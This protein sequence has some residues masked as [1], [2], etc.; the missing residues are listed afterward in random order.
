MKARLSLI[1]KFIALEA[2]AGLVLLAA[3]AAAL[4]VANS[5]YAYL[6]DQLKPVHHWID[7]GLMVFF[8]LLVGIEIK[9]ERLE[10]H[11][12]HW[13]QCLLPVIAAAGGVIAPALIFWG[14]NY[15]DA[16]AVHGWAIPTAT[17]IAFA[18]CVMQLLGKR[19]P[20]SL[21]IT[22]VTI[23]IVDDIIAIGIIAMFYS[24][25][26]DWKMLGG[27]AL[28][29]GLLLGMNHLRVKSLTLYLLTGLGLWWL[30]LH[31][32]IHATIAGVLLALCLP[33]EMGRQLEHKL[34][35][36]VAY[37]IMPLFAFAN[38]GVSLQG[39]SLAMFSQPITLGIIA[40]LVLGKPLGVLLATGLTVKTKICRLPHEASL[41]Q[42]IGMAIL[43]G[44]GFTMSLFIGGL[45]YEDETTRHAMRL[46]VLIASFVA[47]STGYLLLR[48]LGEIKQQ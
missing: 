26:I 4:L 23:A 2:S 3:A 5:P 33:V 24:A 12:Q 41:S 36:V 37:G 35:P 8:F 42:Y 30:I 43:C 38:A 11:L 47:A 46:G 32:G 28:V 45:S 14:F 6:H 21:K 7:D 39:M 31:S 9:R 16:I 22:L 18:L 44:I 27:A 29:I 1:K 10:G 48:I 40:G 13:Q 17:D 15:R 19:V 34:H 20:Q 25:G